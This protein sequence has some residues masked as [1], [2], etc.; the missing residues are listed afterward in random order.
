MTLFVSECD[1]I[2]GVRLR[3]GSS[4]LKGNCFC[5]TTDSNSNDFEEISDGE[6]VVKSRLL[7]K[8]KE[9][10]KKNGANDEDPTTKLDERRTGKTV[11]Y[12]R[13]CLI[14]SIEI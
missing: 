12:Y 13:R 4:R 8:P 5:L 10:E 14:C 1:Q 7:R 9:G 11:P 2:G 6:T 3:H